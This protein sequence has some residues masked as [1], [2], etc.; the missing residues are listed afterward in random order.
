MSN[1]YITCF[2]VH[3]HTHTE[4]ATHAT[5]RNA[6]F[7][8]DV[9]REGG[10]QVME[11]VWLVFKELWCLVFHGGL[12]RFSIGTGHTVPCLGLTPVIKRVYKSVY[13]N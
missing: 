6:L 7:H 11:E 12:Q 4:I 1:N 3:A 2:I 5:Y 13:S 9:G 10:D 8:E